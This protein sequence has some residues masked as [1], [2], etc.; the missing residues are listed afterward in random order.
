M[1]LKIKKNRIP[2]YI[3]FPKS[4]LKFAFVWKELVKQLNIKFNLE[5]TVADFQKIIGSI[6]SE[7]KGYKGIKIIDI[8]EKDGYKITLTI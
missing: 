6:L 1:K 4:F 3:F 5:L 2:F 7:L 8:V